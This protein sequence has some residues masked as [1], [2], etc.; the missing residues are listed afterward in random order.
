LTNTENKT[1]ALAPGFLVPDLHFLGTSDQEDVLKGHGFSRAAKVAKSAWALA[2][3][4][5]L[6][7]DF[8][9]GSRNNPER[10]AKLWLT[11]CWK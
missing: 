4:G 3:E 7:Q 8:F 5:M 2:P 6:D 1:W 9:K 10:T 11:F